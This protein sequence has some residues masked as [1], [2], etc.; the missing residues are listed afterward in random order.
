MLLDVLKFKK[1]FKIKNYR[2]QFLKR[3]NRILKYFTAHSK[4][5]R[6]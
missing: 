5:E 6:L 2:F 1:H 3:I 4:E